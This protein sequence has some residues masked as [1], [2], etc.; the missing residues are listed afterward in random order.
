MFEEECSLIVSYRS[1]CLAG[2]SSEVFSIF[3]G[4]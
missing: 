2:C 3:E 4:N 1:I